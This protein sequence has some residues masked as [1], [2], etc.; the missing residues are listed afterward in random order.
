MR[1]KMKNKKNHLIL[2]F[3]ATFLAVLLIFA[4]SVYA[5]NLKAKAGDAN[6]DGAVNS[7]D[8]VLIRQYLA[9]Y[10]YE[11]GRSS[12]ELTESADF[13]G[14][15]SISLK[16]IVGLRQYLVSAT[17]ITET[18]GTA[19]VVGKKGLEYTASGYKAIENNAFVINEGFEIVFGEGTFDENFN[20][21]SFR[22]EASEPVKLSF[23]TRL[24]C[25]GTVCFPISAIQPPLKVVISYSP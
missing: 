4:G 1:I 13:D 3:A 24:P 10:D 22:Y 6:G 5:A 12:I 19:S 21:L 15:G 8:L 7:A 9:N 18:D 14:D 11:T 20:R 25:T 23:T 16:D 2:I 17:T